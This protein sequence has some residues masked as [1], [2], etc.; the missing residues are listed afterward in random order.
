MIDTTTPAW[1]AEYAPDN[2]REL[3]AG[4]MRAFGTQNVW[5]KG[6]KYHGFGYHRSRNW[7]YAHGKGP[8]DYS[9]RHPA[10][11]GGDGNWLAALDIA[12]PQRQV[13]EISHRLHAAMRTRDPRVAQVREYF[14]TLDGENV[15]GWSSSLNEAVSSD[16]SH[17]THVHLSFY[18]SMADADHSGLL[19]VIT[20]E[21]DDDMP[22]TED[23][24]TKI[25]RYWRAPGGVCLEDHLLAAESA[26]KD[27]NRRAE[28]LEKQVEVLTGLV[29]QLLNRPQG[30][31]GADPEVFAD[32]VVDELHERTNPRT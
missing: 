24:V 5:I 3:Q 11:K 32:A 4:V 25:W 28:R 15:S 22:M 6:D 12:V 23:D 7:I 1:R 21:G 31:G 14:G 16:D 30:P 18:R 17:L 26:A 27:A 20:N 10:D 9:V 19:E 13:I 2:L 29:T 8:L